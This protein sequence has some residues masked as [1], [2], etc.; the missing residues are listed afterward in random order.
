VI[1]SREASPEAGFKAADELLG[2]GRSRPDALMATNHLLVVGMLT[3]VRRRRLRVPADIAVVGFDDY[4][5]VALMDP[6]LTVVDQVRPRVATSAAQRL[7]ERVRGELR[8]P[9]E[10]VLNEPA[11]IVRASCGAGRQRGARRRRGD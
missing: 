11:L 5:W 2:R 10:V 1:E 3:A 7:V 4:P 6:P 9:G 8:G